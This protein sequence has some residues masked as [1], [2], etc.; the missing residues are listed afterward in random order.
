MR[1]FWFFVVIICLQLFL[2]LALVPSEYIRLGMLKERGYIA[3]EM[4]ETTAQML[5]EQAH[6]WYKPMMIDSG[7]ADAV[8]R[9]VITDNV[10]RKQRMSEGA[11]SIRD[12][13]FPYFEDRVMA[14]IYCLYWSLKRIALLIHWLPAML[15]VIVLAFWHGWMMRKVKTENFS[16]SSPLIEQTAT[17]G[18][19]IGIFGLLLLFFLPFAVPPVVAP[20]L[21]A[22]IGILIGLSISNMRKRI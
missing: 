12:K 11:A 17:W 8:R 16:F 1:F 18:S 3:N 7:I 15:P 9:F 13:T 14:F 4:G 5:D 22:V 10:E 2:T 19:M 20:T 21:L 6:D